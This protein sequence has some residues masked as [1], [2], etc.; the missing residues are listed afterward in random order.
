MDGLYMD[1]DMDMDDLYTNMNMN[2]HMHMHVNVEASTKIGAL[3][4]AIQAAM[5]ASQLMESLR[6]DQKTATIR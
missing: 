1:M 3:M 5:K 4:T 2:M 6:K